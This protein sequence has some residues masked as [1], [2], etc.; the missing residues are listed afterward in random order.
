MRIFSPRSPAHTPAC[1][2]DALAETLFHAIKN[3]KKTRKILLNQHIANVFMYNEASLEQPEPL[4]L[5]TIKAHYA[6]SSIALVKAR[7]A[8][9]GVIHAA[10]EQLG[11]TETDY[12]AMVSAAC[13]GRSESSGDLLSRERSRLIRALKAKGYVEKTEVSARAAQAQANRLRQLG[14]IHIA[15]R[16][17]SLDQKAYRALVKTASGGKS[18]SCAHLG[19]ED[20]LKVLAKMKALG[21]VEPAPAVAEPEAAE[22]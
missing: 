15:Q 10:K 13:K 22:A 5:K 3:D 6:A 20:R 7:V 21:F 2:R 19:A 11:L 4:M 18:A 8:D 1:R 17:L 12:R 9:L 14:L 16:Q